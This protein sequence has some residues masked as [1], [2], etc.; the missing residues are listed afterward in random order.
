MGVEVKF[1]FAPE[2]RRNDVITS[3]QSTI[4]DVDR[5]IYLKC[6]Q[7][8]FDGEEQAAT[9]LKR[10]GTTHVVLHVPHHM[11]SSGLHWLNYSQTTSDIAALPIPQV[12][13]CRG[14]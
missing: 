5:K 13:C 7:A 1:L 6:A 2:Q 8:K 3:A 10:E 12:L 4:V 14:P 11:L 9:H